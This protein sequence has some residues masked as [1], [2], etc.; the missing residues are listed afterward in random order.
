[1]DENEVSESESGWFAPFLDEIEVHE[2]VI[3]DA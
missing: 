3:E 2:E 1:M